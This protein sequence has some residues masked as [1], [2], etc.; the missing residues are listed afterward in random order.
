M[1]TG[2]K[3]T[4]E[5]QNGRRSE[6]GR[7]REKAALLFLVMACFHFWQCPLRPVG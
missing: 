3:L 2:A 1:E 4:T 7:K 5:K 6:E